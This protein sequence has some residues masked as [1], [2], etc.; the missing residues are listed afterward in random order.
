MPDRLIDLSSDTATR[1]SAEMRRFMAEAEVG[2]E[3]NREDPTVNLL[4]DMVAQLL[5]KEEALFLPSGTMCNAI[6]ITLHTRPGDEII[7]DRHAHPYTSEGGGPAALAGVSVALLDGERGVFTP[8]QVREA[9]RDSGP[10]SPRSRLLSIENT[11]NHGTGKIWPLENVRAVV[12]V[13]R[14]A[15]LR[16]HM[17]GARLMNA[18]VASGTPARNYGAQVDTIWLDLS[19]GLGAPVGAVLA[20]SH[21][22]MA[23][24]RRLKHRF[25]GAMRQAGIIA[26]GGVYAL[27]YNVERMADDHANARLLAEGLSQIPGIQCDPADI[28]TNIVHFDVAETGRSGGEMNAAF[29]ARGVRMGGGS[30]PR[31]RAVTHLDVSRADIERAVEIMREAVLAG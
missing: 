31:M 1:P 23:E 5:G 28:E 3:Q 20:G 9:I 11:T 6:A 10:H 16:V 14:E 24:A 19:K 21:A 30:G 27:R 2:D 26:A 7:L 17:D 22:D 8:D 29:T 15:G 18:A 13:A 4:Q 25:G 12:A